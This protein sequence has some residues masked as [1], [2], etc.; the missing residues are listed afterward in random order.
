[1]NELE[2]EIRKAIARALEEDCVHHDITTQSC[3]DSTRLGTAHF[4]LKEKARVAG[5]T[6][7]PWIFEGLSVELLVQEGSDCEAGTFLAKVSGHAHQLL[8]LERTA[9]NLLQHASAIA[10]TTARYVETAAGL[11]DILDTRKTLPGLRHLQ[12]YAVR[13]GG[14]VNHRFNLSDRM[15]IK[16]NHLALLKGPIQDIVAQA[17]Q[18]HPHLRIEMEVEDLEMVDEALKAKVDFILLDNMQTPMIAEAVRRIQKRAYVEASGGMTI[19]RIPD[20]A[21]TGVDGISIGALTHSVKAIDISLR[22]L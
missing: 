19:D 18:M 14:G 16:N 8:A 4:L 6:F 7:L 13:V 22:L 11:C 3:V 17:R 20:V 12:K 21:A 10:T 15:L 2:K 9:L 5:L 1:M